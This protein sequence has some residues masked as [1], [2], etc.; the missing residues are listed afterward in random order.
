[1]NRYIMSSFCLKRKIILGETNKKKKTLCSPCYG[2]KL[3][4]LMK[5]RIFSEDPLING[6]SGTERTTQGTQSWKFSPKSGTKSLANINI[7]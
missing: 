4:N 5:Q 7:K 3:E 2:N 6:K 1:M